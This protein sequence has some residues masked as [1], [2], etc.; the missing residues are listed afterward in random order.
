LTTVHHWLDCHPPGQ[1]PA[2]AL[3]LEGQ[4]YLALGRAA[5]AGESF[6]LAAARG[7]RTTE[8]LC[9]QADAAIAGGRADEAIRFAQQAL[10]QDATHPAAQQLAARLSSTTTQ[11]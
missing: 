1:E 7:D 2:E 3:V 8:L 9:L 4:T 5:Q 6:Q 11:R 10:A